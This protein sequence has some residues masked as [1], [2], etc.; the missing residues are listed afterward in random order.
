MVAIKASR[1]QVWSILADYQ[2]LPKIMPNLVKSEIL[3][4]ASGAPERYRRIKQVCYSIS[5]KWH[6]KETILHV[7]QLFM[8]SILSSP[9]ESV[10]QD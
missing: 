4:L 1:V 10:L 5:E 8:F 2:H 6:F 9:L 3:N 7:L